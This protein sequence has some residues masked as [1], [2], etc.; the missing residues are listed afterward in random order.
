M[1]GGGNGFA[2][3]YVATVDLR[4]NKKTLTEYWAGNASGL[5]WSPSGD[6][7]LFTAAAYVT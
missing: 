6:E 2:P 4:R 7:I 3:G 5:A 1:P